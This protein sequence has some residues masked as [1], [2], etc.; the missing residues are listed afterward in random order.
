MWY[1]AQAC[2][3]LKVDLVDIIKGNKEK[4]SKRYPQKQFNEK[5]DANR[6]RGDV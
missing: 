4:L 6:I 3:A 2:L 5:F 1:V